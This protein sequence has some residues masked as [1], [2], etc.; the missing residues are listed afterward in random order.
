M[1][2]DDSIP[3]P[4]IEPAV[5]NVVIVEI[6]EPDS[7][8]E[9]L[10]IQHVEEEAETTLKIKI[11]ESKDEESEDVKDLKH[12]KYAHFSKVVVQTN[13]P[14]LGMTYIFESLKN[15]TFTWAM[16]Y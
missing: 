1:E 5:P 3:I 15:S 4:M 6:E 2:E 7:I 16:P 8:G 11:Q 9:D 12:L 14:K 13:V 10:M